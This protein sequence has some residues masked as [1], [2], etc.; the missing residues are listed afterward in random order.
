MRHKL[1]FFLAI[2]LFGNKLLYSQT[3]GG[4]S[5]FGF[6]RASYSPQLSALGNANVSSISTD[7]SLSYHNPALLRKENSHQ[8]AANFTQFYAGIQSV[9]A[10]TAHYY[11]PWATTFSAGVVYLNYGKSILTDPSGNSMGNFS[12]N[13]YVTQ[14]SASKQ[15]LQHWFYGTTLKFIHSNYAQFRASGVAL[16]VGLNYYDSIRQLQI[17]FV[18]KNMGSQLTTYAGIY[19]DMP[20]DIQVG[21]TK[22]LIGSPL[23]FSLTAQRLH[24]FNVTYNDTAFNS[25]NGIRDPSTDMVSNLFRHLILATEILVSDRFQFSLGFNVLRRSELLVSNSAN[26]LTGFSFG[27]TYTIKK[28]QAHFARSSY[29]QNNGIN[30]F[31]VSVKL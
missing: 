22:R 2:F 28:M 18:A 30:Q 15:Y 8:L 5:A 4:T 13:E 27:V 7:L 31:G 23:Q 9:Q 21:I 1:I 6:L 12:A 29:Q 16:D 3:L 20:F 19:E 10:L 17:G 14:V 24:Q 26:G 25:V 11:A